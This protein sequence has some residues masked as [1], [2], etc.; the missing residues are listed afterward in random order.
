[1]E[2]AFF[3]PDSESEKAL[4]SSSIG[5]LEFKAFWKRDLFLQQAA[6]LIDKIN[7]LGEAI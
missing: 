7:G 3:P 6:R 2:L 1:M 4:F 5:T